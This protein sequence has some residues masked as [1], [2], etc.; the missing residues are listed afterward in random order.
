MAAG[1]ERTRRRLTPTQARAARRTRRNR[2]R[3]VLRYAGGGAAGFIAFLLT[4]SLFIPGLPFLSTDGLGGAPDGPG[5]R[6]VDQ[7]AAHVGIGESHPAYNSVPA[8]SGWHYNLP[9]A[10]VRW[11]IHNDF[12]EEEYRLHNL[13][14]GGI[15]IHYDCPDGCADLVNDLSALVRR[16]Q[17][18]ENLK[19][20]MSPYPGMETRIALTAWNFIDRLDAF[21]EERIKDFIVAHESSPN[22]PEP[23]A[24]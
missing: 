20:F 2:R 12:V 24:R 10:P 15:G 1:S 4:L 21:D 23:L 11:G 14:H 5:E 6:V 19:V 8:T 13:E 9:L 7:G 3:R 17:E 22:S 16:A 18:E